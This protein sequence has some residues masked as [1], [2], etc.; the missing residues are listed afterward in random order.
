VEHSRL[1]FLMLICLCIFTGCAGIARISEFPQTSETIDFDKL[2][3]A[4]Y[5]SKDAFWNLQTEYEYFV[6]VEKTEEDELYKAITDALVNSGYVVSY[7]NKQN[8]VIIGER[9]FRLNEWKSITG[10]YY[11]GRDGLFQV[12]F[13]NAITQD[14]TGG[15]RQNRARK[16]AALL[17]K[18]LS[19]CKAVPE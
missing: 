12:F 7:S 13:R 14:I 17:C 15:W 16:V 9:G 2:A 1:L 11:R 5:E 3:Q 4:N 10:V 8:R 18:S 19:K 6:E